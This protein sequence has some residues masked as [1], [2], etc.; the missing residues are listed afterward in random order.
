[1]ENNNAGDFNAGATDPSAG[2]PDSG[3]NGANGGQPSGDPG[4]QQGQQPDPRDAQIKALNRALV[5]AR[6]ASNQNPQSQQDPNG[7]NQNDPAYHYGVGLK[8]ATGE[9]RGKLENIL[10]L[11][12]ELPANIQAQ[13]RKNPWG[14]ANEDSMLALNVGNGLLDVETWIANYVAAL[15]GQDNGQGAQQTTPARVNQNQPADPAGEAQPDPMEDW[16]LP[17]E[18]LEKKVGKIKSANAARS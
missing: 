3:D 14:Y 5:E 1:M 15:E 16:A 11:Y 2:I 18:D 4:N 13:I 10:D 17:M 7:D 8:V 9:L 12:P 6:R